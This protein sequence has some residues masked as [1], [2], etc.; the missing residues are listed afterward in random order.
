MEIVSSFSAIRLCFVIKVL[1]NETIT[2]LNL[3]EYPLSLAMC[4]FAG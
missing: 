3:A 2:L 1:N 4:D